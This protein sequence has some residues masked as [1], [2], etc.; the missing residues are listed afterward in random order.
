MRGGEAEL[1]RWAVAAEYRTAARTS[2]AGWSA[3]ELLDGRLALLVT[4]AHAHG[5]AG[6]LAT[7]ALTGALACLVLGLSWLEGLLL[8]A[9]ESSTDAAAVFFLMRAGGLQLRRRV[10]AA[11]EIESGTNDPFAVF[12]TIVLV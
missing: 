7:A 10:A 1:G 12:L 3:I 9:I 4:E 8:G 6:A 2:G 5:V 11:L